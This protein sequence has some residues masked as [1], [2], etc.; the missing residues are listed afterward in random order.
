VERQRPPG[1]RSPSPA[2]W[3]LPWL[4]GGL[5]AVEFAALGWAPSDRDAWLLENLL[6]VPLVVG[7]LVGRR[8]VPLTSAGWILVFAFLALHEVG[9]HYTYS[10]VPWMEWSEQL[11]GW[12]PEWERNHYDRFLHFM[13]GVLLTRP[14][15]EVLAAPLAGHPHLLRVMAICVISTLSGAY[16]LMEWIAAEIVDPGLGVGFVGAQGD[17]WDAQKD[18]ALALGGNLLATGWGWAASSL[19]RSGPGV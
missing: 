14:I 16:E 13:F 9:S 6:A 12:S 2:P 3:W 11:L 4:L 18:M 7:L 17:I 10:H 1:A 19:R 8:R 15:Q 5:W